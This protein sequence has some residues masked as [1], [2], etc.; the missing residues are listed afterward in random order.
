M[1][2]IVFGIVVA[3]LIIQA[4][5]FVGAMLLNLLETWLK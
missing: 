5:C 1:G 4:L 3:W 2:D